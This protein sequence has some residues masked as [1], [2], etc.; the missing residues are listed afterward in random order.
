M[1]DR[2][3]IYI[4]DVEFD[5]VETRLALSPSGIDKDGSFK[6]ASTIRNLKFTYAGRQLKIAGSLHK[7][8]KRNNY[9]YTFRT[10][11]KRVFFNIFN[12]F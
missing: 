6:Y 10:K 2:I 1:I 5:D 8:A 11:F 9:S 12:D 7:Y 3:R 4:N